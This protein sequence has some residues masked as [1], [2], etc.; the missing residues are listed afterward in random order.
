MPK[1][2]RNIIETILLFKM[3]KI[4]TIPSI[5]EVLTLKD[6]LMVQFFNEKSY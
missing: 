1:A 6:I 2:I 4:I 5:D 3:L